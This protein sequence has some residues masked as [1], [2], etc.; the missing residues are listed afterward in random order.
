ML[1]PC[2]GAFSMLTEKTVYI[3]ACFKNAFWYIEF[4][5][6]LF[7]IVQFSQCQIK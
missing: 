4:I 2:F 3:N 6:G 1:V 7:E 5:I